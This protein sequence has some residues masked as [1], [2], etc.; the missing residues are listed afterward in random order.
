MRAAIDRQLALIGIEVTFVNRAADLPAITHAEK[1]FS[2]AILPASLPEADT[3]AFLG[4]LRL[5][6]P[7]PEILIYANR[8]NFQVWS[9]VLEAGC[10]D[11]LIEPFSGEELRRAVLDAG[12]A[13][14]KRRS[15]ASFDE[16]C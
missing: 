1:V 13:F 14:E 8:A 16:G 15:L 4:E 7:R 9:G 6:N 3:W 2:V 10:R 12:E 5:L 11:V